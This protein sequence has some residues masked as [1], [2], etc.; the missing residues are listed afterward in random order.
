MSIKNK[1]SFM[2]FF[3]GFLVSMT[4]SLSTNA[5]LTEKTLYKFYKNNSKAEL[6]KEFADMHK[7]TIETYSTLNNDTIKLIS[8]LFNTLL[9]N[10]YN[11]RTVKYFYLQATI[12]IVEVGKTRI[13]FTTQ[14]IT[15]TKSEKAKPLLN[16]SLS[17]NAILSFIGE[18]P[19]DKSNREYLRNQKKLST[20][21]LVEM[22]RNYRNRLSFMSEFID[23]PWF[24]GH[25]IRSLTP[26]NINSL[27]FN[28]ELNEVEIDY[29]FLDYGAVDIY[30]LNDKVWTKYKTIVEWHDD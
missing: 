17:I 28:D 19:I 10:S 27:R 18:N 29:Q 21:E 23:F 16:D 11:K 2:V 22:W 24:E 13:P 20:D 1:I 8:D 26:Y 3:I 7:Q 5:Q 15:L 6:R 9:S 30:R 4:Y 25:S 14:F 12:P